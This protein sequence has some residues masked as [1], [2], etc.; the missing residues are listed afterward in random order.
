M[1]EMENLDC[2][3]DMEDLASCLSQE[4]KLKPVPKTNQERT[5]EMWAAQAED[6]ITRIMETRFSSSRES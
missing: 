4:D 3:V 6:E 1:I 5:A 2:A